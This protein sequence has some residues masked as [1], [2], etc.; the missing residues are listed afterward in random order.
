MR[1]DL[2]NECNERLALLEAGSERLNALMSEAEDL[3]AD[4]AKPK[5]RFLDRLFGDALPF[6]G[7]SV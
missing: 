7:G 2:M 6:H 4:V 1:P 5:R 3:L